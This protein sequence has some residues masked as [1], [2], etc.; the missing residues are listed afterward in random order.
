MKLANS[1][2][3]T[4]IAFDRL[5]VGPPV[6]VVGGAICD[7]ARTRPL[8]ERMSQ[9]FTVFNYDRRGRGNSGNTVP[10]AVDRELEDLAAVIEQAGGTAAVYGHSSGAT[11]V[12]RASAAGLPIS[13]AV[14]HDPPFTPDTD[15]ANSVSQAYA[16]GLAT[17]LEANRNGDALALFMELVGTPPAV[18]QQMRT[19]PWWSAAAELAPT[20]A[21]DSAVMDHRGGSSIPVDILSAATTPTMVVCGGANAAWMLGTN[22]QLADALPNSR[23]WELTGQNHQVDP[24]IVVPVVEEFFG[25]GDHGHS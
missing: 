14:L 16:Q 12:L 8:A 25:G 1:A 21:H 6:I 3:G 24:D 20:L 15:D 23:Y 4:A 22:Q 5:G 2:D 17:L 18:V 13:K 7:R 9:Q 19:Q 11:L 10:Y